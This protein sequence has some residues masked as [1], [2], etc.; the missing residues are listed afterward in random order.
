[1]DLSRAATV[2]QTLRDAFS[3]RSEANKVLPVMTAGLVAGVIDIFLCISLATLVFAGPLSV[4]VGRGIGA[5]LAGSMMLAFVAAIT[6]SIRYV[7]SVTQDSSAAILAIVAAGIVA[8][9]VGRGAAANDSSVFATVLAAIALTSLVAGALFLAMGHFRM[10]NLGR[11]VPYPVVGGFLAGT[12]WLLFTG[13]VSVMASQPFGLS[14]LPTQ[15]LPPAVWSWLPGVAFGFLLVLLS[16]RV[17]HYLLLP[18]L[19]GG[20]LV[21][22]HSL[23]WLTGTTRAQAEAMGLLLGGQAV[24]ALWRPLNPALLL[25]VD[26]QAIAGQAGNLITLVVVSFIALLMNASGLELVGRR[27]VDLD[28]ELR[29][30]GL[31]NM[32]A[33][34][35]GGAPGYQ[36]ISFST[37]AY[38]LGADSR[39]VGILVACLYLVTLVAGSFFLTLV[40]KFV[41]GG[42][43]VYLGL[44]FLVE[45]LYE[46]WRQLPHGDYA[47]VVLIAVTIAVWGFL[48]GLIV[49]ALAAVVLFVIRYSKTDAVKQ[50]LSGVTYRSNVDRGP[51]HEASLR[52]LGDQIL[53]LRLQGYLFFGTSEALLN[54]VRARV[55]DPNAVPLR[56]LILD[57]R[58]VHGVDASALNSFVRIQH[59]AEAKDFEVLL[60]HLSTDL[61]HQFAR[62]GLTSGVMREAPTGDEG[63]EWCEEQ[64]LQQALLEQEQ[65]KDYVVRD[66][67]KAFC[68]DPSATSV[69]M[70]AFERLEHEKDA[71]LMRQ[72]EMSTSVFLVE[73]GQLNVLVEDAEGQVLRV[74]RISSGT[75]VG[76]V[77]FY[78]GEPRTATVVAAEPSVVYCMRQTTLKRLEA[79]CPQ[80]AMAFHHFIAQSVARRTVVMNAL[81]RDLLA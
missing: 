80:A 8:D 28:R 35:L 25:Q 66:E 19:I 62:M 44:S 13:G 68:P 11:F 77:G 2:P 79:E 55:Y 9:M 59:M 41:L 29:S 1:M 38:R 23:L 47:I 20:A 18:A 43:I 10:G 74:R 30:A 75:V 24:S 42:L 31:G 14:T 58:L 37:L 21:L 46:A 63:M 56:Y 64:L 32:M 52:A 39:W 17:H 67:L 71:V 16:R 50:T 40:P 61:H 12:G 4:M 34:L 78:L 53:M 27:D 69:L 45:W 49:G 36:S 33:G 60:S 15:L 5:F 73:T 70:T 26:W 76:E 22:F 3:Q 54:R 51:V 6:S 48:P 57:F 7:V 72:G 65:A 81:V